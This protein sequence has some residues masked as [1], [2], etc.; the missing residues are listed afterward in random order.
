MPL[1]RDLLDFGT[2]G[3]RCCGVVVPVILALRAFSCLLERGTRLSPG[4]GHD[5]DGTKPFKLRGIEMSDD[6]MEMGCGTTAR[7]SLAELEKVLC[8]EGDLRT[9]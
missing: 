9:V 1:R 3:C 2:A 4:T 6:Q 5:K 7:K 8:S